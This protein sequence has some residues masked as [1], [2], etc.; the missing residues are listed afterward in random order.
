MKKSLLALCFLSTTS[1]A[2]VNF[3]GFGYT[4]YSGWGDSLDGFNIF[5]SGII[6]K[7]GISSGGEFLNDGGNDSTSFGMRYALTSAFSEGS[8]YIGAAYSRISGGD[9]DTNFVIGYA[10]IDGEGFDYDVSITD[11]DY[12]SIISGSLRIPLEG[13]MGFNIGVASDGDITKT[14]L[15]L[16]MKF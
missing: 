10:K 11:T 12:D 7:I 6:E 4:Q 13:N 8:P 15:G 16:S 9:S 2:N 5:Y 3:L 1:I 14:T